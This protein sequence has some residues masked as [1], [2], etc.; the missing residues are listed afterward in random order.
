MNL[1]NQSWRIQRDCRLGSSWE[2]CGAPSGRT[3]RVPSRSK[4]WKL[5]GVTPPQPSLGSQHASR[6]VSWWDSGTMENL[7]LVLCTS[8]AHTNCCFQRYCPT[9]SPIELLLVV[10]KAG[11]QLVWFAMQQP[12]AAQIRVGALAGI[13]DGFREGTWITSSLWCQRG[14]R[15]LIH[16]DAA[17]LA[18]CKVN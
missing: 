10:D 9:P 14:L 6:Q 2:I 13:R 15:L 18:N 12:T 16:C 8:E 3:C 1:W 5:C 4:T 17:N 11:N 7:N